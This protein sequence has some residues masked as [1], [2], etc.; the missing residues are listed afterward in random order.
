MKLSQLVIA[1]L[2]MIAVVTGTI[3]LYSHFTVEYGISNVDTGFNSTY[4][5]LD[6]IVQMTNSTQDSIMN[7]NPDQ[8]D[9]DK[10]FSLSMFGAAKNII[11]TS[12][13]AIG[14]AISESGRILNIN[15]VYI[16]VLGSILAISIL[17]A[18]ISLMR[19]WTA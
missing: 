14:I 13:S 1:S 2:I 4:A 16:A 10:I 6:E 7:S 18:F 12:L 15:P 3:T 5:K 8:T 9:P 11:S 17:F 19:G